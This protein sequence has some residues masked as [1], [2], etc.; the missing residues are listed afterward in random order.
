MPPEVADALRRRIEAREALVGVAGLGYIGLPIA[1]AMVEA[2]FAV[3]G[4]DVDRARVER[5][6]RGEAVL[7][8]LSEPIDALAHSG[9][10]EATADAARP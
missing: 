3:L 8:H 10:F 9:R 5:L 1:G 6:G 7:E 4:F 2:G